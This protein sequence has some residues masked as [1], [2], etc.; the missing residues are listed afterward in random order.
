MKED[1]NENELIKDLDYAV[2]TDEPEFQ[3][4]SL[5][6]LILQDAGIVAKPPK[7]KT[8]YPDPSADLFYTFTYNNITQKEEK[9][10]I[11]GIYPDT[12]Y[13][14]TSGRFYR[15]NQDGTVKRVIFPYD[16]GMFAVK[17]WKDGEYKLTHKS[18]PILAWEIINAK[19]LPKDSLVYFKDLQSDNLCADNLG[20]ILRSEYMRLRDCLANISGTLKITTNGTYKFVVRYREN[21]KVKT[22]VFSD[23]VI[24]KQFKDIILQDS[25]MLLGRYHV[26]KG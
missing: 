11:W 5:D 1:F 22:K 19:L 10:F 17:H 6:Y 3:A 8:K 9:I 7:V 4:D 2:P 23:E 18:P 13:A 16:T 20:V 21:N 24:A 26:S 15:I 14:P 12:G 25:I